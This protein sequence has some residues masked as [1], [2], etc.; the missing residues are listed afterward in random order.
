LQKIAW[1][2]FEQLGYDPWIAVGW[3]FWASS[4]IYLVMSFSSS[5]QYK[6]LLV[7]GNWDSFFLSKFDG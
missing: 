7:E 5:D 4:C 6:T 3:S 2:D 1:L